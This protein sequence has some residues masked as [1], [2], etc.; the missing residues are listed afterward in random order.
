MPRASIERYQRLHA[1]AEGV[2]ARHYRQPLTLSV[3]AGAL[4]TSPRQLE[5][6]YAHAGRSSFREDL[7]QARLSAGAELLA[8]QAIPVADV[9]RLVGYRQASA[10]AT[11]FRRRYGLSPARY[12]AAARAAR[13]AVCAAPDQGPGPAMTVRRAPAAHRDRA[14]GPA[15]SHSA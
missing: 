10:F 7:V 1:L 4:S 8:E 12:R 2:I 3:V 13:A 14:S 11:S 5:R 9:A 15:G 6:A